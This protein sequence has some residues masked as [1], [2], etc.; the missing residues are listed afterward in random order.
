MKKLSDQESQRERL[1]NSIIGLGERSVRK[2]YYPEL[3]KRITELEKVNKELLQ[4]IAERQQAQASQKK[5]EKQLQQVRKME[6]IGTLAGGIA[7]DFNN[8][9]TSIIGYTELIEYSFQR[10]DPLQKSDV[11]KDLDQIHKAGMRAKELVNQILAFSRQQDY[12]AIPLQIHIVIREA[13]KFL[14]ASIPKSIEIREK[15][16]DHDTLVLADSTQIHQVV[17]NLCTNAYHSMRD[18]G[19]I[20][21]VELVHK[22]IHPYDKKISN[23]QLTP[24]VY[25]LLKISDTGTG[26]PKEILDRI[27]DPYFTT[28]EKGEGTGMGLAVVHGIIKNHGGHITVYSEVGKGTS[29]Y[30]YLPRIEQEDTKPEVMLTELVPTGDEHILIIDDEPAIT[31][32]EKRLIEGLGY[33]VT[34]MTNPVDALALISAHPDMWDLVLTDMTMPKMNGAELAQKILKIRSDMPIILCTGFSE[35]INEKKAKAIGV[36][37]YVMKPMIRKEIAQAIRRSLDS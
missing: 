31:L 29:F 24:G 6:A 4:E 18:T 10:G 17:M 21:A 22:E 28:K 34:S 15:I 36:R 1:R 30:I 8:I 32:M 27:F 3:Q 5:L 11:L 19:G 14:K 26:M 13:L 12:Q 2:S 33:R 20:L 16:V 7:H 25:L 35:L 9:L 23:L 37:E